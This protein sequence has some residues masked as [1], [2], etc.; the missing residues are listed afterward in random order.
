M[1][2]QSQHYIIENKF[3]PYFTMK[4]NENVTQSLVSKE[5]KC[6]ILLGAFS[7]RISKT[8]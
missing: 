8:P 4:E 1:C 6:L 7:F 2:K 3:C 5:P